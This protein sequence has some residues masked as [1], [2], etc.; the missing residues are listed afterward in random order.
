MYIRNLLITSKQE[1][2]QSIDSYMHGL[3]KLAQ[4]CMFGAV[5]AKQ[6]KEQYMKDVFINGISSAYIRQRLLENRELSLVDAY[7]QAWALEQVQKQSASYDSY[8]IATIEAISSNNYVTATTS[9]KPSNGLK[10]Y[11]CGN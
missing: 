6:N 4:G 11:F 9:K 7:H 10:C 3:E 1:K 2:I 5:D 8:I